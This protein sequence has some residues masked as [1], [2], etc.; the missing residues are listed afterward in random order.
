MSNDAVSFPKDVIDRAQRLLD[1][2]AHQNIGAY[3]NSRGMIT[4]RK[5]VAEYL[6]RRDGFKANTDHVFLTQGASA[7]IKYSIQC[8][9]SKASDG[10]FDSPFQCTDTDDTFQCCI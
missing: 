9:A 7:G 5:S 2:T 8:L 6:F 3:T 1:C 4:I 10:I